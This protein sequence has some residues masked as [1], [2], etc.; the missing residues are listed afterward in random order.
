MNDMTCRRFSDLL[1]E[2]LN[3]SLSA[4]MSGAIDAHARSCPECGALLRMKRDLS[5]EIRVPSGIIAGTAEAVRARIAAD[6][7]SR[8]SALGRLL[9]PALSSLCVTLIFVVGFLAGEV[10]SLREETQT[11]RTDFAPGPPMTIAAREGG[12]REELTVDEIVRLLERLP[13]GTQVL[14]PR[15]AERLT[16]ERG[17]LGIAAG[18]PTERMLDEGLTAGEALALL[19]SLGLDPETTIELGRFTDRAVPSVLL[20]N[21]SA[22]GAA[23]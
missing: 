19:L 5:A 1:E 10:R 13:A 21:L 6:R 2:Y 23:S 20:R 8:R 22:T 12:R 15:E 3:G 14:S 17:F 16:R 18:E 4:E 9:I 11:L 7:V